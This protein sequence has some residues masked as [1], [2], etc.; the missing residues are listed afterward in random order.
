LTTVKYLQLAIV[1][2]P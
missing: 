1:E 2:H